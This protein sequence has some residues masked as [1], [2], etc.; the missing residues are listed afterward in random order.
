[1]KSN[2]TKKHLFGL[3]ITVI[4]AALALTFSALAGCSFLRD[5]LSDDTISF[6]RSGLT[7][8]VGD[9][10]NLADIIESDSGSYGISSSDSAVVAVDSR[11]RIITAK[12]VG[13]AYITAETNLNEARLKVTVE[14]KEP[15]SLEIEAVGELIQTMGKT[16]EIS[17]VPIAHG[18][19]AK[20]NITWNINGEFA[21]TLPQGTAF[22]YTPSAP[23]N[24]IITAMSGTYRTEV[25]V[26]VFYAVE[27]TVEHVGELTQSEQ[28]YTPITF[29][30]TV[31]GMTGNP[32]SYIRWYEDDAIIY[33]GTERVFSYMPKPGRRTIS[34]DVNGNRIYS[35]DIYCRGNVV[36]VAPTVQFDN[37]YPHVYLNYEVAGKACVEIS[38][39]GGD[40]GEYSQTDPEFAALFENGRMDV[41]GLITLCASSSARRSY[42]FRV[43]SLGDGDAFTESAYSDYTTF[44]QLPSAAAQYIKTIIPGGDLYVTSDEEYVAVAEYYIFFRNKKTSKP[45]VSF[46][47]Y[48]AYDRSGS[49]QDLWNDAFPIAAT[50]GA[51]SNI[52]VNDTGS[53]MRTSFTV[54][55]VNAPTKQASASAGTGFATQLHAVLPHINYDESKYRDERYEFPIDSRENVIEVSYTDELYLV[56]QGEY[57]RPE[58]VAGSA[59]ETVYALARDILRKICT[60][61]MTDVQKA[62]AIYDWIMWQVTYDNPAAATVSGGEALSAY[63]LEGVFGNGETSIGGVKYSPNAVCDGMSKAYSLMCNIE[64]IPCVRVIGKAGKSLR[65]AGGHAWNKVKIVGE[66]Y[67]VDCTWGDSQAT[68]AL[69]GAAKSY[70]LGL[71]DHLFLTDAQMSSTHYE[72]Y[73]CG[74]TSI[75]YAP[76]TAKEPIDV[77]KTIDFDGTIIN[78]S[79]GKN[80]NQ[81]SRVREIAAA[82]AR[83]YKSKKSIV[84]PGGPNGGV[85]SIG[86]TGFEIYAESGLTLS[87]GDISATVSA[88]IKSFLRNASVK[89]FTLD[90]VILVLVK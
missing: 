17:F 37:L 41:G 24:Y 33:E 68:M 61:D 3:K 83:T 56:A 57:A 6:S 12:A 64:G 70:E 25:T 14:E 69:D 51:Y 65:D 42:R 84:V 76:R 8:H 21:N 88:E 46:D 1:M 20:N 62:H 5:L 55:T 87:D 7:L 79:I 38:S 75:R 2:G 60:D 16:S 63:Y 13:V 19:A 85:Y 74:E 34:A 89:V 30:V 27:A 86:Y 39:P 90:N 36:P 82:Y 78:C 49:A 32:D 71:H 18:N 48:I 43:K 10:Y 9:T 29:T 28:P 4:A 54:N 66:W 44:T 72:P 31:T 22:T 58:P 47:C 40:V 59:A 80:E 45:S 52:R 81:K 67:A 50:S 15:D 23:G 35:T 11:T 26:R 77:Y 73:Q 53:I